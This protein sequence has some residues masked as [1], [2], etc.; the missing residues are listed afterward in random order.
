VWVFVYRE[1]LLLYLKLL[2]LA[3]RKMCIH[4][5]FLLKPSPGY[6]INDYQNKGNQP[7]TEHP[8][9]RLA[10]QAHSNTS[11]S[12]ERRAE[13]FCAGYDAD[14][15][16]LTALGIPTD[17]LERLA[18]AWLAAMARTASP[19][20]TGPARFPVAR[21]E[22]LN[23]YERAHADRYAAYVEACKRPRRESL[24]PAEELE[25]AREKLVKAQETH[26]RLKATPKAERV[27]W[28]SFVLPYALRDVK[29]AQQ[30]VEELEKRLALPQTETEHLN[31]SLKLVQDVEA[32]RYRLY[33][34]SRPDRATIDQL[35][36][37]GLKWAPSVGAWQ[38]QITPN[39]ERAIKIL[40]QKLENNC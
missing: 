33:F 32:Q 4:Q 27:N 22:K 7:M 5:T 26:A 40:I 11:F 9:Y 2:I 1:L 34:A 37:A 13:T 19:M 12:P 30:R 6:A 20:I 24:T 29:A 38:R 18:R 14:A 15:A 8:L 31:G 25:A 36:A 35:K 3:R 28:H 39:A 10:Y 23:R 16:A 17:K 21:M